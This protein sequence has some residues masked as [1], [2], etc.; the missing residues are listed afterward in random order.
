MISLPLDPSLTLVALSEPRPQIKDQ[1]TG[2]ISLDRDTGA[3]LYQLDVAL[4][5]PGGRPMTFQLAVPENGLVEIP[6][7]AP[8][9]AVG[10]TFVS[11]EKNG[12]TWQMYRAAGITPLHTA[13]GAGKAA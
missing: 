10:L 1:R 12:R 6:A 11:G 9:H 7:Y 5:V 4:T 13:N 3:K 8:F 2:E